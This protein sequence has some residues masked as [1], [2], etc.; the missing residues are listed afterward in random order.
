MP[1]QFLL[2]LLLNVFINTGI[3]IIVPVLPL[4]LKSFGFSTMGLSLPF[5]VLILGRFL[6]KYYAGQLIAWFGNKGILFFCFLCSSCVFAIY[7]H[8]YSATLF[9]V[10]RFFEGVVEGIGIICLTDMAINLSSQ[11]R[12][13]LMGYFGSSFG[14]GF[15]L[16]PLIGDLTFHYWGL[17]NMFYCGTLIGGLGLVFVYCLSYKDCILKSAHSTV[18]CN[19]QIVHI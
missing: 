4:F 1:L 10:V 16:G 14:L 11:Q 12:G 3:G 15:I 8:I 7:P 18:K 19:K 5:L 13:K 6:S 17:H 9:S 2:V